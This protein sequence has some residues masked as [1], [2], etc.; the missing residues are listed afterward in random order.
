MDAKE[1]YNAE[2]IED[3]WKPA[4]TVR[5]GATIGIDFGTTNSCIAYWDKNENHTEVIE[6]DECT[7]VPSAVA[8]QVWW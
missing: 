6:F 3:W 2:D 8:F 1:N 5:T 7:T 4:N